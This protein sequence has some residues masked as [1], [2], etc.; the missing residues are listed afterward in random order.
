MERKEIKKK[1]TRTFDVD[2]K[3]KIDDN[4][5]TVS[6]VTKTKKNDLI[7]PM[8]SKIASFVHHVVDGVVKVKVIK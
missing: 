3:T 1:Y 4:F 7:I 2:F 8:K 6:V 5:A